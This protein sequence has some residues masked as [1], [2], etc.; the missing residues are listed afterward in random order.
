MA[1]LKRASVAPAGRS[2]SGESAAANAPTPV[3]PAR[4]RESGDPASEFPL[5]WE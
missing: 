5:A 4:P 2:N 3:R 1:G